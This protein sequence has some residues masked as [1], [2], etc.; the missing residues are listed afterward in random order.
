MSCEEAME[1]AKVG[2]ARLMAMHEQIMELHRQ[3]WLSGSARTRLWS[4]NM[5]ERTLHLE[6][7]RLED[8]ALAASRQHQ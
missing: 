6:W 3:T 2:L 8:A 4:L 5:E 1:N 7:V